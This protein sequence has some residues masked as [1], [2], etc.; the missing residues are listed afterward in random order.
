MASMKLIALCLAAL[1]GASAA[2]RID[3][4]SMLASTATV[5]T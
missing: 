5:R 1:F 2:A 4:P 3:L